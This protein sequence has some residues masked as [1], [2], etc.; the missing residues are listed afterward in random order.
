MKKVTKIGVMS[1][2][3]VQAA[4]M[5]I[6]YFLASAVVNVIGVKNPE[7]AASI[8]IPSG[9]MG[10]VGSAISGILIG[11]VTGAVVALVYNMVAPKVGAIEIELK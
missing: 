3:K 1:L 7:L 8:G 5:G 9:I 4:V 11:F 2:A 6:V 10:V